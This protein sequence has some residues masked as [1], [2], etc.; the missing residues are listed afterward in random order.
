MQDGEKTKEQLINELEQI[1]KQ[2]AAL[3]TS[4]Q[5]LENQLEG[6]T[7][8][9]ANVNEARAVELVKSKKLQQEFKNGC[10]KLQRV[11]TETI[12]AL[13]FAVEKPYTEGHQDRV[14]KLACAIA[15]GMNFSEDAILGVKIAAI[16]HDIGKINIPA[17]ILSKP[18]KLTK[19]EYSM[20][21]LHPQAG[22][23]IIKN[24]EFPWPVSK[25]ILQHHE[26][27]DG[28]GYPQGLTGDE[29]IVEAR[30]LGVADVVE[31]M[32]APRPHRPALGIEKALGEI[33]EKKGICYD[34]QIVDA[35]VRLF[36]EEGFK[37]N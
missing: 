10:G 26:K 8:E 36:K 17:E 27:M 3:K 22:Y 6:Q 20:I 19:I 18:S 12:S 13:S 37:L 28:T 30:I 15:A 23:E 25:A 5:D 9:L 24:I 29:I 7:E 4:Y 35:C 21:T 16:I 2:I 33:L 1:R 11:L 14:A 34:A 31:A 32:T